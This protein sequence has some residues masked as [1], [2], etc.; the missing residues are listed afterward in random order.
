[1]I[2]GSF[3]NVTKKLLVYNH[4]YIVM[5][6]DD[7]RTCKYI[8]Y[9]RYFFISHEISPQHIENKNEAE[10]PEVTKQQKHREAI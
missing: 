1:M 7:V 8:F 5:S 9:I 2:S 6:Q 4:I 3:R 10:I